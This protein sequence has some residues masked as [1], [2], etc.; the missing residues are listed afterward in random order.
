MGITKRK[1]IEIKKA[2]EQGDEFVWIV[3]LIIIIATQLDNL[4]LWLCTPGVVLLILVSIVLRRIVNRKTL[5]V[6]NEIGIE[7]K[8]KQ[9][10]Y[11]WDSIADVETECSSV[12]SIVLRVKTKGA[13]INI[14]MSNYSSSGKEICEAM[15]FFTKGRI[16]GVERRNNAE[17]KSLL[18]NNYSSDKIKSLFIKYK[19]WTDLIKILIFIFVPAFF[20]YIQSNSDF[21]YFFAIGCAVTFVG[22]YY[23]NRIAEAWF[24][25]FG[26]IS[27]LTEQQYN[28]MLIKMYVKD[29]LTQKQERILYWGVSILI[30]AIFILSYLV[31]SS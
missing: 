7:D 23:F 27:T 2:I 15:E 12:E 17:I 18:N 4:Q 3:V 9:K 13:S 28:K 26:E 5:L 24:K 25:Q 1:S 19:R 11:T 22:L 6:I 30:V 21:P 20:I 10:L 31:S 16:M 29:P 14:N 8:K